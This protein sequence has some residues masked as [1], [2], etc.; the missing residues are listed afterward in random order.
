MQNGVITSTMQQ[1]IRTFIVTVSGPNG[2]EWRH[3]YKCRCIN[4]QVDDRRLAV[5]AANNLA[6]IISGQM[7]NGNEEWA[8]TWE[9]SSER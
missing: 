6:A 9:E 4:G 5:H 8:E 2:Q 1:E 3:V 7:K